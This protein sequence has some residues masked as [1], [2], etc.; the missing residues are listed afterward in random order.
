VAKVVY[1]ESEVTLR[2]GIE[3]IKNQHGKDLR[4][5]IFIDLNR[6]GTRYIMKV[7]DSVENN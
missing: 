2:P 3:I 7:L 5:P 6:D 1:K 4:K